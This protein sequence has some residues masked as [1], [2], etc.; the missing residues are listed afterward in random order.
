MS[1]PRPVQPL[2]ERVPDALGFLWARDGRALVGHGENARIDPGTGPDR[3]ERAA[4]AAAR[5]LAEHPGAH[6]AFG[7]F[8]FDERRDGSVVVVPERVDD[9]VYEPSGAA[10]PVERDRIRY[11]GSSVAEVS[12]LEA[13]DAAVARIGRGDVG[14]VVLARDMLVWS[15]SEL[16]VRVLAQRLARRF[17]ECYTFVFDGWVGASPELLVRR[18]GAEVESLVLAGSAARGDDEGRDDALGD[19]LLASGKDVDEHRFGVES[20]RA[21]LAPLCARLDVEAAPSLLRL[22]NVQH[23]ATRIRGVLARPVGALELA[24]LLHPTAAVCGT[25]THAALDA[26]GELEGMDR[27]RYAGPIGWVDSRGDGEWA[28]ALRCARVSG[29]RARL[30]AGAGIVAGSRPEAELEETRLKFRAMLSALEE[31]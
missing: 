21:V 27:E 25:P 18:R 11:A 17:P 3:F 16:D 20:V 4:R 23:L 29:G 28:I 19:A 22:A 26:I 5:A 8:T 1:A 30:F 31:R 24:G 9:I 12:W 10:G 7:H 6:V 14:K 13:V 15:K 2:A